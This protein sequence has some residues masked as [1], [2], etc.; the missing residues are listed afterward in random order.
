MRCPW[1]ENLCEK[2]VLDDREVG[3]KSL[4]KKDKNQKSKYMGANN[5]LLVSD[6]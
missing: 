2:K 4:G 5:P 3:S 1:S 6:P